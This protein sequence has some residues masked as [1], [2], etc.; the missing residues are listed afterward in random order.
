MNKPFDIVLMVGIPGSG[1][2]TFCRERLF[3]LHLYISLD[4]LRTRSAEAE[5]FAFALKRHKPCVIDNTNVTVAERRRYIQLARK[6]KDARIAAYC[7]TPDLDGCLARNEK[8]TGRAHVPEVAIKCKLAKFEPPDFGE[9]I[10]EIYDVKVSEN[11][12]D[13]RRRNEKE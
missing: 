4:Q 2:T 9:G 12:F 8:R 5:L 7:F 1:K 11:V 10:D 13:V 6:E 3:P